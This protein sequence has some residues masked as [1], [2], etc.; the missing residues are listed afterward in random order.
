[1]KQTTNPFTLAL[2]CVQNV[3]TRFKGTSVNP[4][5]SQTTNEWVSGDLEGQSGEWLVIAGSQ[6]NG[7]TFLVVSNEGLNINWGWQVIQ[8]GIALI[9]GDQIRIR[10]S[11][12]YTLLADTGIRSF[13]ETAFGKL[14]DRL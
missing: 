2:G 3:R 8:D 12:N 14:T 4:Q 13:Y 7:V 11:D 10:R 5:E 1:M 6:F 9:R